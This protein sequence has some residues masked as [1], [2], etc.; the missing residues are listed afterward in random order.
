MTIIW[1]IF[2]ALAITLVVREWRHEK[3]EFIKQNGMTRKQLY[4]AYK[5]MKGENGKVSYKELLQ[6]MNNN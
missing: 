4:R 3:R 2:A 1:Y 5:H 6:N